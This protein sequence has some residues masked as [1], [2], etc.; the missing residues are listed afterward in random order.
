MRGDIKMHE[1]SSQISLPVP[2]VSYAP[3]THSLVGVHRNRRTACSD[4]P[5][6]S[7]DFVSVG[8]VRQGALIHDGCVVRMASDELLL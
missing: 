7:C 4:Y 1:E 2:R 5:V 8:D 6:L 3:P